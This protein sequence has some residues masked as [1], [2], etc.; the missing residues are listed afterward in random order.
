MFLKRSN[1]NTLALKFDEVEIVERELSS[2]D[3]HPHY[4]ELSLLGGATII[5]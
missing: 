5:N 1:R 2:Y 4:E 3:Q